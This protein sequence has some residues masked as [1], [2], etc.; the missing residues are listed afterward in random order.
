VDGDAEE[1]RDDEP[2]E[3]DGVLRRTLDR[4]D[5]ATGDEP[6]EE[7]EKADEEERVDR[8]GS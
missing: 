3:C 8:S 7:Q 5:K 6:V 2:D 4:R 1:D